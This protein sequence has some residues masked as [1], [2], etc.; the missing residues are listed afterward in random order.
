MNA[1]LRD[2]AR[3]LATAD[4]SQAFRDSSNGLLSFGPLDTHDKRGFTVGEVIVGFWSAEG[5]KVYLTQ[6][7]PT[8]E[9]IVSVPGP[10]VRVEPGEFTYAAYGAFGVPATFTQRGKPVFVIATSEGECEVLRAQLKCNI[11]TETDLGGGLGADAPAPPREFGM[12]E[13][14]LVPFGALVDEERRWRPGGS[15]YDASRDSFV[16]L[17]SE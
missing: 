13:T 12:E 15:G 8:D 7:H 4:F 9:W 2:I 16:K 1:K 11:T 6:T 5:C 14:P 3:E 17:G 10:Q